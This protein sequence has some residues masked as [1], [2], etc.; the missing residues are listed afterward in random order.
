MS[1][2][3]YMKRYIN[4]TGE[5]KS[6]F[7]V[8]ATCRALNS[9]MGELERLHTIPQLYVNGTVVIP[10]T[11]V[12][13]IPIVNQPI[14]FWRNN[15]VRFTPGEVKKAMWCGDP[16]MSFV[17][18][19][20]L[21]GRKIQMNFTRMAASPFIIGPDAPIVLN[22]T[23]FTAVGAALMAHVKAEN[24]TMNANR[25]LDLESEY[26]CKAIKTIL[27]MTTALTGMYLGGGTFTGT[28]GGNLGRAT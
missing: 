20:E 16:N 8:T 14:G 9:Y 22:T 23:H 15:H 6:D 26:I 3:R 19:F 17:N 28:I 18:L 27:P 4:P 25:F 7:Y 10:G 11:P 24:K 1:F 5:P 21:I 2:K 12:Y 13:T